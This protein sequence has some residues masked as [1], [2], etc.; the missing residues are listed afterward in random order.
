[1]AALDRF[2][3]E[4]WRGAAADSA[5]PPAC[6]LLRHGAELS[7]PLQSDRSFLGELCTAP[8]VPNALG[9]CFTLRGEMRC[10]PTFL[11]I[12]VSKAGTTAL[13]RYVAQHPF[14]RASAVKEPA[15][16]GADAKA[17]A[18]VSNT[19]EP[20]GV[21]GVGR[22]A[23]AGSLAWYLGLF[24]PCPHCAR[25]EATPSYAWR[26]SAA[27]AAAAAA[28]LLGPRL[29]LVLLVREP[30]ERAAS[31][32]LY[33]RRKRF[34]RA[35]NLSSAAARALSE[36]ERCA[37]LERGWSSRCAV[38]QGRRAVEAEAAARAWRAPALRWYRPS[39]REY[40]LLQAGLYSE[41]LSTWLRHFDE[42]RSLEAR[43]H[44]ISS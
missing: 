22:A 38:R 41:H 25:G 42:S 14:V 32:F 36:F 33:F 2:G 6:A 11:V 26:D 37:S 35:P 7:A 12:G 44:I 39:E 20:G 5:H 34:G 19:Q 21:A 3:I 17:V 16:F 18:D 24:A 23:P 13:F 31:H 9:S 30:L 40:E 1:M 10:M 29:R 27:A 4:L 43:W 8:P 15:Y 28:Q